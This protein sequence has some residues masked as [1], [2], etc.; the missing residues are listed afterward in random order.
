MQEYARLLRLDTGMFKELV[1]DLSS[2]EN[3]GTS[4]AVDTAEKGES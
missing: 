1:G 4:Y 3:A 2:L